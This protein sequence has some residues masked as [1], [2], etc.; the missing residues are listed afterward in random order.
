MAL[1]GKID[2]E[3]LAERIRQYKQAK[4]ERR[5][6]KR[7]REGKACGAKTRRGSMCVATGMKNGRCKNHGGLSTGPKTPE[8]K[9]KAL[10]KLRQYQDKKPP[11]EGA[12]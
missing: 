9:A 10:S 1:T 3:G 2:D 5:I 11:T 4:A 6:A 8:G 12:L 7:I